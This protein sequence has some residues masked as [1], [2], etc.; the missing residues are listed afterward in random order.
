VDLSVV[1]SHNIPPGVAL[2]LRSS[3]D[4]FSGNDVLEATLTK[5]RAAAAAL[6]AA[7]IYK[8]WLRLD[9]VGLPLEAIWDGEW[10]PTQATPLLA[11]PEFPIQERASEPQDRGGP[12][13]ASRSF[14][15]TDDELLGA[16]LDFP[17]YD[18]AMYEQFR[19]EVFGRSMHGFHLLL[20]IPEHTVPT[21][22][23][24]GRIPEADARDRAFLTA[25]QA[26]LV[27]DP[28]PLTT[29]VA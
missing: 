5:T 19:D 22:L 24:F 8:R 14:R 25:R 9:H 11:H 27:L 23:Y 12:L 18:D 28:L 10:L 6:L 26:Q 16:T 7:P 17:L 15:W 21:R 1:L 2:Q 4:N 29:F 20:L 13:L 3:T